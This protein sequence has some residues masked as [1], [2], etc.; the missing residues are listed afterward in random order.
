MQIVRVLVFSS[1]KLDSQN[2]YLY[3][4]YNYFDII[5]YTIYVFIIFNIVALPASPTIF[6]THSLK[7]VDE[8]TFTRLIHENF[9]G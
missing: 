3:Y 1:S 4:Y 2:Q 7:K 5:L 9:R 8:I 6:L